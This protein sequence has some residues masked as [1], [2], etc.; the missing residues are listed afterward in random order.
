MEAQ[1]HSGEISTIKKL[2]KSPWKRTDMRVLYVGPGQ[3]A[4]YP[5]KNMGRITAFISIKLEV[6]TER[7][8]RTMLEVVT[9]RSDIDK[10]SHSYW[11]DFDGGKKCRN[12]IAA[13]FD[14]EFIDSYNR[15]VR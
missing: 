6:Y 15:A 4:L 10:Q 7:G 1:C 12:V 13:I 3:G 2:L 11:K 8:I 9:Y 5:I 14:D